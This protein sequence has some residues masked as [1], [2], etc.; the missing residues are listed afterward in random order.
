MP[1]FDPEFLKLT[2]GLDVEAFWAENAR[3][4][5]FSPLK[6]RCPLSF[7]PDDHWLFSF[8]GL[9]STL[10][11]YQ[12][13]PYRDAMHALA[14]E[15]LCEWVGRPYF[16][17]D[18]W[19]CAP[20]RIENLFGCEFAYYEGGT[21]WLMPVVEDESEASASAF[22]RL[23]DRAEATDLQD[24]ALPPDFRAEWALRAAEGRPLQ[25][26]GSGSR[27]PATVMTSILKPETFFY[28][29][30]DKPELIRRFSRLLGEKMVAF[31]RVLREFSGNQAPGWWITDDNCALFNRRLYR[32]YCFP[33]LEQVLEAMA[34][35]PAADYNLRYQ[36]SDSAMGHLLE[37]QWEL[38]IRKVNYGPTVDSG[39]IRQKMPAAWICGQV[40]P[41]LLRDGSP[42][43]IRQQVRGD[44]AK[45]GASGGL[46]VTTAGSLPAGAGIGRMRWLMQ[47]V[48]EDCSYR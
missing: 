37:M 33:V 48:Q 14:N 29:C 47:V 17:E 16:E 1:L 27:G 11:Y 4:F 24:W 6:P 15:V 22:T 2:R 13:K 8:L 19:E 5:A 41:M 12:E 34:P 32:E 3:C 36:H 10:R 45:A 26:L 21:P 42:E 25:A 23:L 44:F 18:T 20:K 43:A 7:A 31:N 40:P 39:L 46:E 35:L 9:P 28:W 30:A 38:G